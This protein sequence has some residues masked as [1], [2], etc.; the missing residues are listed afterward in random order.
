MCGY[1]GYVTNIRKYGI[2]TVFLNS[3]IFCFLLGRLGD[4]SGWLCESRPISYPPPAPEVVLP[5]PNLTPNLRRCCLRLAVGS[6]VSPWRGTVSDG[7][8]QAN[9]T[10]FLTGKARPTSKRGRNRKIIAKT[11]TM[12]EQQIQ[13]KWVDVQRKW[14]RLFRFS[15]EMWLYQT[16]RSLL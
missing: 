1:Q 3:G 5:S 4:Y 9:A 14:N 6:C 7:R 2:L 12:A 16:R 13:R 10:L 11:T 8:G 15:G